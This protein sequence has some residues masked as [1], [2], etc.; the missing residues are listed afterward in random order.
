MHVLLVVFDV[1]GTAV[2]TGDIHA[3]AWLAACRLLGIAIPPGFLDAQKGISNQAAAKLLLPDPEDEARR[4][5]L[6]E[7]K[8]RYVVQ[9]AGGA[10]L[11]AGFD[12]AV[13]ALAARGVQ[14]WLATSSH[15]AFVDALAAEIPTI[16]AFR[17]SG[18]CLTR[19]DYAPGEKA[20]GL[21][22]ILD[23]TGVP[24]EQMLYVGDALSDL[25]AASEVGARF[26]YYIPDGQARDAHILEDTMQIARH[27]DILNLV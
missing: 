12:T 11:Y 19:E 3:R 24:V 2:N 26:V 7:A 9:H 20:D 21:R 18:R 15:A 25:K 5:A 14:V 17:T 13:E 4:A 10:A 27:E 22:L 1:D 23:R 6:I 8:Q 16:A